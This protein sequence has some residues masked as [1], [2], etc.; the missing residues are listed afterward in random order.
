MNWTVLVEGH[1]NLEPQEDEKT[2]THAGDPLRELVGVRLKVTRD[3]TSGS[4]WRVVAR[5]GF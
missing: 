2:S 4:F 5:R 1:G 3:E